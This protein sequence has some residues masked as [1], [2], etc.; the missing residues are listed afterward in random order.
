MKEL[1]GPGTRT[2]LRE[3]LAGDLGLRAELAPD[4]LTH[5]SCK[6]TLWL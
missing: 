5:W 2:V 3:G 1:I 4:S 6:G